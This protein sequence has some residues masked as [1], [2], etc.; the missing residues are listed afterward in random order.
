M[1]RGF[2][3]GGVNQNMSIIAALPPVKFEVIL[4]WFNKVSRNKRNSTLKNPHL[5]IWLLNCRHLAELLMVFYY[6]ICTQPTPEGLWAVLVVPRVNRIQYRVFAR[7]W[8]QW[9]FQSSDLRSF[10]RDSNSKK[11]KLF[12]PLRRSSGNPLSWNSGPES[13]PSAVLFSG[14]AVEW[15]CRQAENDGKMAWKTHLFLRVG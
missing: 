9:C 5:L 6:F 15:S 13:G 11:F 1:P 10:E 2:A 4:C 3:L 7:N 12:S 14:T 8:V